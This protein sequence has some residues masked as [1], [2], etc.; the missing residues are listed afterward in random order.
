MASDFSVP[1]HSQKG[2]IDQRTFLSSLRKSSCAF[3]AGAS[4]T[5]EPVF[6][7]AF[8]DETHFQKSLFDAH[9]HTASRTV[10]NNSSTVL[11]ASF[12]YRDIGTDFTTT[13]V[14]SVTNTYGNAT[15]SHTCTY[16][17]NGNILSD[18]V[19]TN[20]IDYEYDS[21]NDRIL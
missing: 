3:R 21:L 9:G 6:V 2:I 5:L 16:D 7:Y 13:Q 4:F 11:A 19:G 1:S 8:H 10:Q 14:F 17:E 15:D 18:M 20:T 12:G